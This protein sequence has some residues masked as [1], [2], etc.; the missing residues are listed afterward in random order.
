MNKITYIDGKR[1]K[2]AIM[3]GASHVISRQEYLN[4]INVF[5]V[6]DSDTGTNV[7]L[8]LKSVLKSIQNKTPDTVKPLM[9]TVAD[10][11]L[12]DARGNSGVIFAQFFQG[13]YEGIQSSSRIYTDQFVQA[14]ENGVESAYQAVANPIP[15]TILSVIK[16][17]GVHL[18]GLV[19]DGMN[20]FAMLSEKAL[21]EAKVLLA[22]TPKQLKVLKKHNV[23]D[24]G[25]QA[26][27]DFI[28][29][30]HE[31][32]RTGF[33]PKLD[34]ILE[35]IGHH[36][37]VHQHHEM[38]TGDFRYCTECMI[39]GSSI[40]H[41]DLRCR[42]I[43]QGD[44][45]V[46]AGSKHRKRVHIHVNEPQKV[47]HI[48]KDFGDVSGTKADD[49][50]KQARTAEQT[51]AKVA[52]VTDSASDIDPDLVEKLNIHLIP[53]RVQIGNESYLDKLTIYA[54]DFYEQLKSNPKV[55]TT[56]QP[57]IKDFNTRFEYLRTHYDSI[58]SIHVPQRMSNTIVSAQ[59]ARPE[60][61]HHNNFRTLESLSLSAGQ[62]LIV[63]YAA[64]LAQEGLG[65]D[66]I[67]A[68][69]EAIREKT[70]VYAAFQDLSYAVRG[71]R[72][73]KSLKT[74]T[75]LLHVRPVLSFSPRLEGKVK[76]A[77]ILWG[78]T[79]FAKKFAKFIK[80]RLPKQQ[81]FKLSI[82]HSNIPDDA[83]KVHDMLIQ[84]QPNC[85]SVCINEAGVGLG[86]HAGPGALAI[87][88]QVID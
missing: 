44:S 66:D 34:D 5:P 6:S 74:V 50:F 40:D 52:I 70:M 81:K 76:P 84:D 35:Q 28:H 11:A 15:G 36:K 62:G 30:I 78:T 54:D 75:D 37:E 13:F 41:E 25:A 88:I 51:K 17:L 31:N 86:I 14:F 72:V 24:A 55:L 42:L 49:M 39:T 12:D 7:S 80:K 57:N 2:K 69:T 43:E 22:N 82:S 26:F 59:N 73:P 21:E 38:E 48:C 27:V 8:T 61:M 65:L 60:G 19:N 46:I 79:N 56:S 32:I 85:V 67:I 71:G 16:D 9:G 18:R 77:G 4:E 87:G 1:F 23:V 83:Y 20:D 58:L 68:K 53:I 29:G 63:E 64:T 47:F 3:C 10:A 33:V 45:L